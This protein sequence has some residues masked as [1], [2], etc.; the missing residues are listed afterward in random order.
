MGTGGILVGEDTQD[1]VKTDESYYG[2][3]ICKYHDVHIMMKKML[4]LYRIPYMA[5]CVTNV[6]ISLG[7]NNDVRFFVGG[8]INTLSGL[9]TQLVSKRCITTFAAT[10]LSSHLRSM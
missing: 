4:D 7:L 1:G 10:F 5:S 3:R 2:L 6:S 9:T 8:L